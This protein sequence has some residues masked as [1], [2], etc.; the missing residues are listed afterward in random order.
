MGSALSA[1][2]MIESLLFTSSGLVAHPLFF[3]KILSTGHRGELSNTINLTAYLV[4]GFNPNKN[5]RLDFYFQVA[6]L[7]LWVCNTRNTF[8]KIENFSLFLSH[9]DEPR[10]N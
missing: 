1:P 7:F 8:P 9:Y 4:L 2:K 10:T 3:G 6:R 5:K